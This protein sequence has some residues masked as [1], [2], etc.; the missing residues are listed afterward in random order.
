MSAHCAER[1]DAGGGYRRAALSFAPRDSSSHRMKTGAETRVVACELPPRSLC[2]A[3]LHD[4]LAM[5]ALDREATTPTDRN[6]AQARA[7]RSRK[8]SA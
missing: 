8:I 3:S 2:G 4:L 7:H 1:I 5:A 6:A